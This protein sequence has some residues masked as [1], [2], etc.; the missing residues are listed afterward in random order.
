[1]SY[2]QSACVQF[3]HEQNIYDGAGALFIDCLSAV[4]LCDTGDT[5]VSIVMPRPPYL[6]HTAWSGILQRFLCLSSC[7]SQCCNRRAFP[8]RLTK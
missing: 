2:M 4:V 7:F 8:T 6:R 3:R 5:C 1:M